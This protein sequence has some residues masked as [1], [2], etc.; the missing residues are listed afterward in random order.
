[1]GADHALYPQTMAPDY[2]YSDT[3]LPPQ[4]AEHE[5]PDMWTSFAAMAAVPR[6]KKLHEKYR[7][8][9]LRLVVVATRMGTCMSTFMVGTLMRPPPS[10]ART[11]AP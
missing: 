7:E 3:G 8:Q 6:W 11:L 5:Y 10:G 2:P 1:M 4:T 9:G